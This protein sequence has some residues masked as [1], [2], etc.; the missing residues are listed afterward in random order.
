MDSSKSAAPPAA[1][2]PRSS[3]R[4]APSSDR[5]DSWKEISAY[6]KRDARTVRRWEAEE[7]L[8]VHRHEHRKG[9]SVYAY[10]SELDAWRDTRAKARAGAAAAA[11]EGDGM[12]GGQVRERREIGA[13]ARRRRVRM[14]AA[15][16]IVLVGMA[17]GG[18]LV[19]RARRAAAP[20]KAVIRS[21]A[22]LPLEDLSGGK[23]ER[24]FAQGLTD[25]LITDLDQL[26]SLQVASR[27]AVEAFTAPNPPLRQ[28]RKVLG[29]DAVIEGTVVRSGD[30]ARVNLR[31]LEA[32]TGRRLWSGSFEASAGDLLDLQDQLVAQI[33]DRVGAGISP[34]GAGASAAERRA[35]VGPVTAAA[36]DQYLHALY[37]LDHRGASELP[38]GL[39]EFQ[40]AARAAPRFAPAWG[41]VAQAYDLMADYGVLDARAAYPQAEAA[42]R[43]A[44]AL[45]ADLAGARAALAFAE[46]HY[47]W[48]WAGAEADFRRA[49]ALDP[50]NENARHWYGL[51]LLASGRFAAGSLQ[52]RRAAV[53]DP[54]SLIIQTNQGLVPYYQGDL[55]AA[56]GDFAAALKMDDNFRPARVKLWLAL[57]AAGR[58]N[59]AVGELT[60]L[61][62]QYGRGD[63]AGRLSAAARSGGL[64]AALDIYE[65]MITR[66]PSGGDYTPFQIAMLESLRGDHAAALR[67][68]RRGAAVHDGWMVYI[69][70]EPTLRPLRGEP[71]FRAL[72]RRVA[73]GLS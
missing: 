13:G 57:A 16:A 44:L 54:L 71:E 14:A 37:Y 53:L 39:E 17:A 23:P 43:R 30:R 35:A 27:R 48:N 28:V 41:G 52:L 11:G 55:N 10:R 40:A 38:Y 72:V 63:L 45:D 66:D 61:L 1:L 56:A 68:L 47:D 51:Y 31:M 8:P 7:G 4:P 36:Y 19:W 18:G 9:A 21:V 69:G 58:D 34:A 46:W 20:E 15:A 70:V 12:N 67:W 60:H 33:S 6:L 29:V 62:R 73:P 24:Y 32:G 49:L 22:V 65:P 3:P 59:E 50:N 64:K 2:P 25:D 5:L 26:P 42:A